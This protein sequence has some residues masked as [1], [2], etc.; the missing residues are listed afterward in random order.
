MDVEVG[1]AWVGGALAA[2]S[3]GAIVWGGAEIRRA[4][5]KHGAADKAF[6]RAAALLLGGVLGLAAAMVL[7]WPLLGQ[8]TLDGV[9]GAEWFR[10]NFELL[11][12]VLAASAIAFCDWL[13]RAWVNAGDAGKAL[14]GNAADLFSMTL[15]CAIG[16]MVLVA[17][18]SSAFSARLVQIDFKRA[19]EEQGREGVPI[20][21]IMSASERAATHSD[22]LGQIDRDMQRAGREW[23][24]L[25]REV[26]EVSIEIEAI[27]AKGRETVGT[28]VRERGAT[29]SRRREFEL[30]H[31]DN[32]DQDYERTL[33]DRDCVVRALAQDL[34]IMRGWSESGDDPKAVFVDPEVAPVDPEAEGADGSEIQPVEPCQ[35]AEFGVR[36]YRDATR[37]VGVVDPLQRA[38]MSSQQARRAPIIL[39]IELI[40][41]M[42]A[43]GALLRA[44]TPFLLAFASKLAG[45]SA[46]LPQLNGD[47]MLLTL[48]L[49]VVF[50]MSTGLI[51]FIL[52]NAGMN[53]VDLEATATESVGAARKPYTK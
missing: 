39:S 36:D 27:E 49:H 13:V 40:L 45:G 18:G 10:N 3:M 53:A 25:N 12:V 5:I 51:L 34:A 14:R 46:P 19:L 29:A 37:F 15:A 17:I 2:V 6:S 38:W 48:G 26:E 7:A 11:F 23:Y 35:Y 42:G 43:L 28:P 30:L 41:V 22:R 33:R 21:R 44:A 4:N 1:L 8:R 16:V 52:V 31:W 24:R 20:E 50:G 32:L 47:Y 9:S